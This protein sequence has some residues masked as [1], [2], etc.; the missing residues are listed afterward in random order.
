MK[1]G[2]TIITYW[3]I[4]RYIEDTG[5]SPT[6][7]YLAR[8]RQ[9]GVAS[10]GYHIRKLEEAGYIRRDPPKTRRNIVLTDKV[11]Q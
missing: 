8:E 11:P 9:M 6:R 5:M 2:T 10:I 4:A 3:A 7:W 1:H